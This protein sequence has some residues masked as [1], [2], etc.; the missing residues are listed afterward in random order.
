MPWEARG[1]NQYFYHA[2]RDHG[3]VRK[4]YVGRGIP[5][6]LAAEAVSER[7]AERVAYRAERAAV[8]PLERQTMA[9]FAGSRLLLEAA[10]TVH[11]YW[12]HDRGSWRR[13]HVKGSSQV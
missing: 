3:R 5:A 11:G 7:M 13:K 6:E 1:P 12:R 4:Q 10:L 9:I 8:E 2:R